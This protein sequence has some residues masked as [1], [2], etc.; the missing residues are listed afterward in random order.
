MTNVPALAAE[1]PVQALRILL[2]D[3]ALAGEAVV[4]VGE[5]G[6]VAR[7]ADQGRTW[8]IRQAPT[9][10]TL[11]A[12]TF[13]PDGQR[14]WAVGH[15]AVILGTTDG[16][17][18]WARE[19]ADPNLEDS[20]LDVLAL[21]AERVI[22]VGAY[23]L[24]ASTNDGGR[25]WTRRKIRDDDDHLNR[26][27]RGDG[28]TLYL[29]GE[30]G[31]LLRSTDRGAQWTRLEPPYEGS[32]YGV[33]PLGGRSLL[34]YGL[35]GRLFRSEDNGANWTPVTTLQAGLIATAIK[36]RGDAIVLGGQIRGLLVSRDGGRSVAYLDGSPT[37][38]I[39]ELIELT[40]G[41]LLALGEAGAVRVSLSP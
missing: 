19:Y 23:G 30:R 22:A 3:G 27:T 17:R 29:A 35:R 37:A 38:A 14:G 12:I 13:A 2:L 21:D 25:T 6:K 28:D 18:T 39:A 5:L 4:A 31:T 1:I 40:D 16:G 20:F 7:S 8:E 24:F 15:D 10:A 9:H 11:T 26:L 32:F 36:T 33:L 41:T 34:A